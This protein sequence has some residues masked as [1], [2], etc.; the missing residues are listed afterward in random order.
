MRHI[1]SVLI[2]IALLNACAS[3]APAD[4]AGAALLE[5]CRQRLLLALPVAQA[6]W[7]SGTPLTDTAR[8]AEV[9]RAFVQQAQGQGVAASLA[10]RCIR[11]QIDASKQLQ[12][13][14]QARWRAAGQGPFVPAPDL[15]R[16]V[17]PKLDALTPQLLAALRRQPQQ[18]PLVP[19]LPELPESAAIL[20]QAAQACLA[21]D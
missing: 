12:A 2:S 4:S 19:A 17:R 9:E 14:W 8:E 21:R 7:N 3:S 5:V 18:L 10:Q 1:G 15:A 13:A 11:A 16:E 6:K 20:Q